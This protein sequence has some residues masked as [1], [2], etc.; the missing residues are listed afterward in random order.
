[1]ARGDLTGV[2][3]L[4]LRPRGHVARRARGGSGARAQRGGSLPGELAD[5]GAGAVGGRCSL[6][7]SRAPVLATDFE[8]VPGVRPG[9]WEPGV[10]RIQGGG[11]MRIFVETLQVV[12][13][14]PQLAPF[15]R[16]PI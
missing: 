16:M 15:P 14:L 4:G 6:S 12:D 2:S 13:K 3:C 9:R 5:G 11:G 8:R 10:G 1:M 7:R